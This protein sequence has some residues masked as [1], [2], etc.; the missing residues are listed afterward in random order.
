[1]MNNIMYLT[2]DAPLPAAVCSVGPCTMRKLDGQQG[3]VALAG[4]WV[5]TVSGIPEGNPPSVREGGGRGRMQS[6][7]IRLHNTATKLAVRLLLR[8][9]CQ[10]PY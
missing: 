2:K 4:T 5:T 3:L 10:T 8:N 7:L 6:V 9:M 1:M